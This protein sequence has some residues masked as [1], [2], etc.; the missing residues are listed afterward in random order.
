MGDLAEPDLA[1]P[2]WVGRGMVTRVTQRLTMPAV[3][4]TGDGMEGIEIGRVEIPVAGAGQAVVD[5][6][7]TGICGTDVH[8]AHDEYAHERPVVMGHE[9]LGVVASV[10]SKEDEQWVGAKVAVETYFSACEQCEMC[11]AGRRNL[12]GSRR[13]IGSFRNGGFAE[14]L[15][16]PVLNLHR[17]P[18]TPGELDGVLSEPLACVAQCLLDP[19]VVQPGDRVLVTGPGA[20]GQLSAQV[21]KASGGVVTLAGLPAD[22]ERLAVASDV[23]IRT[24]TEPPEEG[25]YDVVI[26]CSGSSRAAAN[27]LRA[28]RR[29]ARYVQVGIFGREVSVPLDLVLYKELT[30]T[31][32]FASTPTSWRAAMR[33]IETGDVLLTPLITGRVPLDGFFDALDAAMRGAGLKTV[34][35]P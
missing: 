26:E 15:L 27:A 8:V 6:L 18:T 25:A 35:I 14:K 13:S 30:V 21:A 10:G 28:A 23:G 29:G 17:M 11:R 9:V 34:V 5:V 1:S 20:M 22:A 4:K 31:S 24:T 16:V 32:G 33:L 3:I 7:A 2:G 12:C 19:P